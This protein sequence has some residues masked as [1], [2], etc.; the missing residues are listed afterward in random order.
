MGQLMF[1]TLVGML[2]GLAAWAITAPF[3]PRLYGDPHYGGW[4][5]MFVLI[6][7]CVIGGAIG[8]LNGFLR[9]GKV[10]TLRGL[11]LGLLLG[12]I[13]ATLGSSIGASIMMGVTGGKDIALTPEPVQTIG[14]IAAIGPLALLIG[15]A[16]GG[17]SLSTKSLRNGALGGALAGLVAGVLFDPIGMAM[18]PLTTSLQGAANGQFIETGGPSRAVMNVLIGGAI[19]LFIGIVERMTRTAWLR[20]RLGRNEGKEWVVDMPQTF[21]GRSER[22]HVPLFGDPA[23]APMHACI[24]RQG[25]AYVLMDSGSGTATRLNGYPIQQA[26]LASGDMITVGGTTLEFVTRAGVA[27]VRSPEQY[28]GQAYPLQG[29]PV[30]APVPPAAA[31]PYGTMQ[32]PAQIVPQQPTQ[33]MPPMQPTTA[34]PA[35]PGPMSL[36][37]TLVAMDGPLAGK[38]YPISMPIDIGRE[39]TAI[40]LAFDTMTSRKHVRLEPQ[41]VGLQVTDLNST[42]GTFVNGQRI[43]A[44][45]V[46]AGDMVKIGATTF[47]VEGA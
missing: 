43:N 37:Y 7:G 11:G 20:L 21:I 46:H 5:H 22:A 41:T 33:A 36:G 1:R 32:V 27:P 34:M 16:I 19:A 8:C 29:G 30:A 15:L 4:E 6:T 31:A 3:A 40:P 10:H 14:R 18:A 2:A 17:A 42:N 23:I 39:S 35:Q 28:I 38:R 44:Q 13:G 47:R 26:G 9:G 24:V 25:G 12:G 45:Q